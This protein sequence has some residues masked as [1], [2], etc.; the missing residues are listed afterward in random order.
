MRADAEVMRYIGHSGP[1]TREQSEAWLAKNA[2]RWEDEGFG[3]WAVTDK[4]GGRLLGWCGLSRLENTREIEISPRT[5]EV[6]R[7]RVME[8]L[9][10]SYVRPAFFYGTDV[11]YYSIARAQ[12]RRDD[13]PYILKAVTSDE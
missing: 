3:M 6:H 9:G 5:I 4:A 10:M 12:F 11:A 7:A 2:R 8:K 1:Q 13:S